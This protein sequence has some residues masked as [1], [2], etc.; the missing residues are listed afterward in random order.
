MDLTGVTI[1]G[2]VSNLQTTPDNNNQDRTLVT[3]LLETRYFENKTTR[4]V[5]IPVKGSLRTQAIQYLNG[6][7]IIVNGDFINGNNN[8]P[9]IQLKFYN[10]IVF[11][12]SIGVKK[13]RPNNQQ[14]NFRQPE[15]SGVNNGLPTS[16]DQAAD[17]PF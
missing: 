6:A 4:V 15:P 17:L 12:G 16:Q 2:V 3:F 5:N 8:T 13:E 7:N 11:P 10:G 1:S 14:G 9:V